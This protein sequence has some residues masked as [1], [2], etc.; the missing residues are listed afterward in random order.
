MAIIRWSIK[1]ELDGKE[2][3]FEIISRTTYSAYILIKSV[4]DYLSGNFSML[5]IVKK[6]NLSGDSILRNWLK[7]YNTPKWNVKVEEFMARKK[8]LNLLN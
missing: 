3:L 8:F 1:Y 4:K 5:D 2:D 6:Y 7:W